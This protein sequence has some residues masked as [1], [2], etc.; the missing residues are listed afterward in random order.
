[1]PAP[2]PKAKVKDEEAIV[3]RWAVTS[4]QSYADR[5]PE[6]SDTGVLFVFGGKG[7]FRSVGSGRE[8]ADGG[9]KLDPA[10]SPKAVDITLDGAK[11]LGLYELNGDALTLCYTTLPEAARPTELKAD[12]KA[13]IV[14]VFLK[15]VKD[16]SKK[17]KGLRRRRRSG[18]QRRAPPAE[19]SAVTRSGRWLGR[20]E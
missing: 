18:H 8:G 9:F 20:A 3:G 15:R 10:A 11:L 13:G 12:L 6:T 5:P 2:V 7:E 4:R 16:E 17:D 14:V 19:R 1:M